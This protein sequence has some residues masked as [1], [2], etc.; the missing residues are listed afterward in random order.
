MI[1]DIQYRAMAFINFLFSNSFFFFC[2]RVGV[3]PIRMN[4]TSNMTMSLL[5]PDFQFLFSGNWVARGVVYAAIAGAL[6]TISAVSMVQAC[7]TKSMLVFT[8]REALLA[9]CVLTETG[10]MGISITGIA[11][12]FFFLLCSYHITAHL[13]LSLL[14]L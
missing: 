14:S 3:G 8:V 7:W 12:F 9:L 6:A 13:S 2:W 5:P 10:E 11:I 1:A 4:M